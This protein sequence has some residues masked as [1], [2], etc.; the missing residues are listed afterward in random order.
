MNH[1]ILSYTSLPT[2]GMDGTAVDSAHLLSQLEAILDTHPWI[3]EL[4]FVHPSQFAAL[5][6]EA[7]GSLVSKPSHFCNSD[8]FFWSNGHKLGI[9]TLA[10]FPLY[11][12]AKDAFMDSFRR[13]KM[14]LDSHGQNN[15]SINVKTLK[16]SQSDLDIVESEAMRHS[17]VLVLL[18]CDFG[19]AWNSRKL[20]ILRKQQ[21]PLFMDELLLS[22]LVLSYAPKSECAWSHR[23][24]VIKMIADKCANLQEIV[25]RESVLVKTIAEN[26]KMNYRAWNH[27]CWL[28]SYMSHAQVIL[29]LQ[30]SREWTVLHV[31][32]NSC[33][34][35]QTRL[36]L[37]MVENLKDDTFSCAEFHQMWKEELHWNEL[38][39]RR[40]FGR[41]G[42]WLHRRF[43]SLFWMK[44][45]TSGNQNINSHSLCK[46]SEND[47]IFMFINAELK[48]LGHC[49]IIPDNVFEDYEAQAVHS[50]TYIMWLAK[51]MP[52][53]FGIE[54]RNSS[55]YGALETSLKKTG[56][57]FLLES[58]AENCVSIQQS[59][60]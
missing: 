27:R 52:T 31:A 24:W 25:E 18:S 1:T 3:D 42:L 53:P 2:G 50:A 51:Q 4:G 34:H 9:S 26:S 28:V 8:T 6:E 37:Q 13:Y 11:G 35:Y 45:L 21:F 56:K 7:N 36:L 20:V 38:L 47:D 54:L 58:V 41:E 15:K 40:Y 23:R 43:L 44:H 48:L 46:S 60:N 14:L 29:E 39:I 12:A 17:R 59:L 49:T 32:D 16:F 33:L 19:T 57:S 55:L 10:L 5:D 22:T 30:N